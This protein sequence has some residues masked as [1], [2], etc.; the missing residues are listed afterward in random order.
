[1][2]SWGR[3]LCGRWGRVLM[4]GMATLHRHDALKDNIQQQLIGV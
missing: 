1:M 4:T 2:F 3:G